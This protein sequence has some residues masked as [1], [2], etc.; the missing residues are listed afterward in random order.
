MTIHSAI[1]VSVLPFYLPSEQV[2]E[3]ERI[4]LNFLLYALVGERQ[5]FR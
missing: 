4:R 1:I 5:D 2:V 3:P